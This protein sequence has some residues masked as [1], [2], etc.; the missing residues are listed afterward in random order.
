MKIL[1][2]S[3]IGERRRASRNKKPARTV[4]RAAVTR[5]TLGIMST[6]P[7][8]RGQSIARAAD[9]KAFT[10]RHLEIA[11]IA[12]RVTVGDSERKSPR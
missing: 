1:A 7:G 9:A 12:A 3:W 11:D 4:R 5:S 10:N 8:A 6:Q 2:I